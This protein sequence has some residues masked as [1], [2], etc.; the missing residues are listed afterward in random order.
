MCVYNDVARLIAFR[1]DAGAKAGSA[2]GIMELERLL[3][4]PISSPNLGFALGNGSR[5]PS[6]RRTFR[7]GGCS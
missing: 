6:S 2:R 5:V 4:V 1:L 7:A 3:L